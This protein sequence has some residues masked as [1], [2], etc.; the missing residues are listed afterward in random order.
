MKFY[1][2]KRRRTYERILIVGCLS[3]IACDAW[4][5]PTSSLHRS[6]RPLFPIRSSRLHR[7]SWEAIT[8]NTTLENSI[9]LSDAP[10]P[11]SSTLPAVT[12]ATNVWT[13]ISE[14]NMTRSEMTIMS[15]TGT[16]FS[17]GLLYTLATSS[18]TFAP[19]AESLEVAGLNIVDA[20]LPLTASDFVSVAVGESLAGTMG[21]A[22]SY[23]LCTALLQRK[24]PVVSVSD[25]VADGDFLLTNA[26]AKE[27]LSSV[28]LS[29]VLTTLV[30]TVVAI[31]PYG[32]VKSNARQREQQQAED[33]LLQELLDVEQSKRRQTNIQ[34][35][36]L[37][38]MVLS[39]PSGG[40]VDTTALA[41]VLPDARRFDWVEACTDLLKWLQFD[42]LKADFG[43]HLFAQPGL[44]CALFGVIT[45]L[46]S[47]IYADILYAY[48]G[49]GGLS[50]KETILART[51]DDW[52]ATY[53]SKM[54]Y[55]A[56]LFGAYAALQGPAGQMV[57]ALGSGGVDN[58]VG[59]NNY[60]SC[61]DTF[62]RNN[63]P[64][65]DAEFRSLITA[66]VSFWNN[67]GPQLLWS[68][69]G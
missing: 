29:P 67:H 3:H 7:E 27:L 15:A 33:A 50:K 48:F 52:T 22:V 26:A 51:V 64:T 54:I 24:N 65:P 39:P 34:F 19:S 25:A 2:R 66:A 18:E 8:S 44:E 6:G 45:A 40:S 68:A 16:L 56:V 36:T 69:T 46:T 1:N 37:S 41:P 35:G 28:G 57:A 30:A 20:A 14:H 47:Q 9:V 13:M 62:V 32:I 53:L 60:A 49:L 10:N 42:V 38:N 23:L 4:I 61:I 55:C 17:L 12:N 5:M 31:I 58:C 21:A 63:S 11:I 59:S 43:G